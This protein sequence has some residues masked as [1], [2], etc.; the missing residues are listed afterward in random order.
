MITLSEAFAQLQNDKLLTFAIPVFLVT[1][2]VEWWLA[3]EDMPTLYHKKDFW[4][5]I[6]MGVI[7]SILELLP[8]ALGFMAL[9][10]LHEISPLRDVVERQ[11][12]AW[13]LLFFMDDFSYYW[14]HRSNHEVRLFWAGHVN[15]HSSEYLN[16]GTALRQGIGERFHKYI[17][18]FWIA[19]LGFDPLMIFTMIGINLTLQFFTHTELVR[20][21]PNWFEAFFNTPSHHRVHHARNIAY[22]DCNHAG[23]LIIWD[24]FFG[25]FS[26]EKDDNKPVYGLT[27]NINTFNIT[28]VATHE[29]RAI[30]RDVKR[31]TKWGDKLRYIFMPPG[32][33]HDGEDLRAK[34]LR[35]NLVSK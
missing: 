9:W 22:L 19:F 6:A 3:R 4:V 11:W 2:L 17:F 27:T 18:W 23:M 30:W 5:S 20:R 33:S 10:Y 21:M 29:Y 15:H 16:F 14:F 7:T 24:K 8:K 1:A 31:A 32:W 13:V 25:T 12:W 26:P 34:T 35:R 28:T